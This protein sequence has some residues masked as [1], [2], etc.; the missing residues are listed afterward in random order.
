MVHCKYSFPQK[1]FL[2]C[3]TSALSCPIISFQV[4]ALLICFP[5]ATS[6]LVQLAVL[7]SLLQPRNPSGTSSLTT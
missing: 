3:I 4:F 5:T 2:H 6:P 7:E 1:S